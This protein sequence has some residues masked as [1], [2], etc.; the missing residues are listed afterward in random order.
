[1]IFLAQKCT[2]P[3]ENNWV[4]KGKSV[5]RYGDDFSTIKLNQK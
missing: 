2:H 1:M 4:T 3:S 5:V